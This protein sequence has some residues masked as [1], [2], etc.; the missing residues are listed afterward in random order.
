MIGLSVRQF[1]Q[2][3]R[4]SD[5]FRRRGSAR[6][7]IK[8]NF[9]W[10][11]RI[12]DLKEYPYMIQFNSKGS[13]FLSLFGDLHYNITIDLNCNTVTFRRTDEKS[14][15]TYETI[16]PVTL[17]ELVELSQIYTI[18]EF[19]R[20]TSEMD[21]F[22]FS[23][24]LG[25][26]EGYRDGWYSQCSL[27]LQNGECISMTLGFVYSENPAEKILTWIRKYFPD[28]RAISRNF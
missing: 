24:A 18:E 7:Q 20:F 4:A 27:F 5:G 26:Y 14:K 23:M 10:K 17:N 19:K 1:K 8:W 9:A 21:S 12:M 28:E 16:H 22:G 6:A 13:G 15:E 2:G 11:V 25:E 3:G